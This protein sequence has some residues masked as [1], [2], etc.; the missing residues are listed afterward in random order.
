MRYILLCLV[1]LLSMASSAYPAEPLKIGISVGLTGKYA[2]LSAMF[3]NG[4]KLWQ[5]GVNSRNG[6]LGRQVQLIVYDDKSS[7]DTAAAFYNRLI[8]E[9]K[10][11]LVLAPYSSEI[12]AAVAP[13]TEKYGYSLL[14]AG[15]SA[16][17]LWQNGYKHL[18]G[19]NITSTKFT[20]GFLEALVNKGFDK[21]A[22]ITADDVFSKNIVVG[23]REWA[24][25]FGLN[26]VYFEEFKKGTSDL[27]QVVQRARAS[28]AQ[29]LMVSGHMEESINARLALKNIKWTPHA[30]YATVGPSLQ[31]FQDILKADAEYVFSSSQWEPT[32]LFPNSKEFTDVFNKTYQATP[33]YH[34]AASYAAGQV[35][36][37]AIA[38]TKSLD[39]EKLRE[40]L[41][42]LDTMT[43]MGRYG[44]DRTGKQIRIFAT[45]VQWQNGRKETVA[46]L[47][48]MTVQPIW[49]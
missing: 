47:E 13:I 48:A 40:A 37:A 4:Y 38:K 8:L 25:R 16:D 30:Y 5:T 21:V 24:K 27:D 22:L 43:I 26:I 31:K 6:L 1:V 19:V 28:G 46:P 7:P 29:V 3:L 17:S 10:V 41:S 42:S 14:A 44:V 11:D 45:I 33:S 32:S 34:A 36:E 2:E 49:K 23:T 20:V 9:D 39:K 12:T 18:F 15:G 35:M